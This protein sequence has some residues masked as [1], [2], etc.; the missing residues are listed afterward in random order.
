MKKLTVM[1]VA[2]KDFWK[3]PH[4]FIDAIFE[5][6]PDW[7]IQVITNI[8]TEAH[9]IKDAHAIISSPFSANL[10]RGNKNL[11]WVHLLS[12]QIPLSWQ[13]LQNQY[14][15]TNSSAT[16]DAV[17]EHALFLCLKGLRG[18]KS[19][20]NKSWDQEHF[21][22]S[23]VASESSLGIIGFG[24]IGERISTISA[25]L[26]KE[27]RFLTN[28][29]FSPDGTRHFNYEKMKEFFE[30]LDV[31]IIATNHSVRRA[32]VFQ[33]KDFFEFL[34]PDVIMVNIARGEIFEEQHLVDFFQ[35]HP[36]AFYLTDVT[37][38]EPY[39][40]DGRLYQL[41][42]G[43]ISPHVGGRFN[44]L[45]RKLEEELRTLLKDRK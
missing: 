11:E 4:T 32:E 5:T 8:E 23:K 30:G 16:R 20:Q 2:Q 22:I 14:M 43:Y 13:K 19:Y 21:R 1:N 29:S 26:F 33:Q 9:H 6:F 3:M 28:R 15:V 34:R 17:A 41:P 25:P 36:D 12:A 40:Q 42:N 7:Q 44:S 39:P 38:P 10:V 27:I 35:Q 31:V 18:E 24:H 45:W 37:Y